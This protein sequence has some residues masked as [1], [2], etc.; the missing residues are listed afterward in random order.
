MGL[1]D[2][3][4]LKTVVQK[5]IDLIW[6]EGDSYVGIG[7]GSAGAWLTNYL[8][9]VTGIDPV[10]DNVKDFYRWWRFCSTSRS[11]SLMDI[12]IDIQSLVCPCILSC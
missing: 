6:T 8:L 10:P 3:L 2:G 5:V 11:S 4:H 9:G 1:K 12:D 7:R